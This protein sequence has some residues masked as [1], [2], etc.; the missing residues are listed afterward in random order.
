VQI[1][2]CCIRFALILADREK[3]G[4]DFSEFWRHLRCMSEGR[5]RQ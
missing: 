4:G 1:H 3:V 2:T 5:K